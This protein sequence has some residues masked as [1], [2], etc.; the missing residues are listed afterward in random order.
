MKHCYLII[1]F[2]LTIGLHAQD[3]IV[4]ETNRI[5]EVDIHRITNH[6]VYYNQYRD[7]LKREYKVSKS[8]VK[9]IIYENG[10]VKMF[11]R[12]NNLEFRTKNNVLSINYVGFFLDEVTV[13]Y[14]HLFFNGKM[15]LKIPVGI[16]FKKNDYSKDRMLYYSGIDINYYPFKQKQLSYF[17]GLGMRLGVYNY[18]SVTNL[19][20]N[21]ISNISS[22]YVITNV[23]RIATG[24]YFNNGITYHITEN[25]SVS[26]VVGFGLLDIEGPSWAE[27]NA[28]GE[29]NV[30]IRF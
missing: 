10:E 7:P 18:Y 27:P 9:R 17:L 4:F 26:G 21:G 14:E 23:K 22:S 15:G 2:F 13:N 8:M 29:L 5:I 30:S 25:M 24:G 6:V 20:S 16:S 1:A 19:Y 3:T 11:S 12:I 28:I